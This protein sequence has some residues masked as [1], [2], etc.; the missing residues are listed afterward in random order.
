MTYFTYNDPDFQLAFLNCPLTWID[1]A[2]VRLK[3][4][5]SFLLRPLYKVQRE[6]EFKFY[7]SVLLY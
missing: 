4:L 5:S 7:S 1:V 6:S 3:I 2:S